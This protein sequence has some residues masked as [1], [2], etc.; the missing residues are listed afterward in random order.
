MVNTGGNIVGEMP[1]DEKVVKQLYKDFPQ[2][3][4]EASE[5][6]DDVRRC[7]IFRE[8]QEKETLKRKTSFLD[9]RG[10]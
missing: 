9:P 1:F 8:E 4:P 7:Q 2:I 3:L 10:T 6:E 5:N